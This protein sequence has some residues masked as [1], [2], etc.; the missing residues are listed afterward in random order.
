MCQRKHLNNEFHRNELTISKLR[1][2]F[3]SLKRADTIADSWLYKVYMTHGYKIH[4]CYSEIFNHYI[5]VLKR[6]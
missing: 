1:L 4:P 2:F 3:I 6:E 5:P